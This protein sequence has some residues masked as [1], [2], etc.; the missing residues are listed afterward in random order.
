M[1][2][3][4]GLKIHCD[5]EEEKKELLEEATKQGF[6]WDN[7]ELELLKPDWALKVNNL[8]FAKKMKVR[9]SYDDIKCISYKEYKEMSVFTKDDL[10]PCM[11]VEIER[12]N[13]TFLSMICTNSN[14]E[15]C[16]SGE[17]FWCPLYEFGDDMIYLKNIVKKVYGFCS[18]NR[19][20][21]A[22]S[23]NDRKLLWERKEEPETVEMTVEEVCKALGKNIKI[24][25][26]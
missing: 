7:T 20:A 18:S 15:L 4:K 9:H 14:D 25:K 17:G 5:N 23:K 24:V 13:K 2:D 21:W 11:V 19:N 12:E 22:V 10:K 6:V 3:L 1:K 16:V 8:S 26:E